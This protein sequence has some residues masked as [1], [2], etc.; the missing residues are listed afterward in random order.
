MVILQALF[1]RHWQP[2]ETWARLFISSGRQGQVLNPGGQGTPL[3]KGIHER[4]KGSMSCVAEGERGKD[5][6]V[7]CFERLGW[8]IIS[9][10]YYY[11]STH[12]IA[13]VFKSSSESTNKPHYI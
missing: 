2:C 7:K 12:Y 5:M 10:N 4:C 11:G 9:T 1:E 3:C 8:N 6:D 13:L